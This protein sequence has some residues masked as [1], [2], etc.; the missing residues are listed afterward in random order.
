MRYQIFFDNDVAVIETD[1]ADE[2]MRYAQ[3]NSGAVFDRQAWRIVVDY[4]EV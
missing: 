2:A 4:R 3:F 1:N